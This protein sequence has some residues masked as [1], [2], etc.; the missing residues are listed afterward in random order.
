MHVPLSS[1]FLAY[2]KR[3]GAKHDGKAEID[4]GVHTQHSAT[5]NHDLFS[6]FRDG[7]GSFVVKL[8]AVC[9]LGSYTAASKNPVAPARHNAKYR[10]RIEFNSLKPKAHRPH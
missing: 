10:Q 3:Q 6:R 9:Q 2:I 1:G 4:Y 5:P 7:T 8:R